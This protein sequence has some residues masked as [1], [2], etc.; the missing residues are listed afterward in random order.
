[1]RCFEAEDW[2]D[3]VPGVA[4]VVATGAVAGV[5]AAVGVAPARK[6]ESGPPLCRET[7]SCLASSCYKPGFCNSHVPNH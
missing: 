3:K 1:M 5:V 6:A 2:M 7:A 4:W